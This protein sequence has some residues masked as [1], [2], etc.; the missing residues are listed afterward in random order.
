MDP[1]PLGPILQYGF[2]G[3]WL[4]QF[5]AGVW[6]FLRLVQVLDRLGD[7]LAQHTLVVRDLQEHC[8]SQPRLTLDQLRAMA[9]QLKA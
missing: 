8:R 7:V 6:L 9:V 5:C 4:I 2:A 3:A 1:T